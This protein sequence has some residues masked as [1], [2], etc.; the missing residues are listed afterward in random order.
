MQNN[1]FELFALIGSRDTKTSG[2]SVCVWA[3]ILSPLLTPKPSGE[4]FINYFL[5]YI[6]AIDLDG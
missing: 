2:M 4:T 3:L 1:L 5:S 6:A